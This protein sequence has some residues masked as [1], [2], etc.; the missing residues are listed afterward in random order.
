M[1]N[2]IKIKMTWIL[3]YLEFPLGKFLLFFKNF[4]IENK[5]KCIY[6]KY[7]KKN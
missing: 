3:I 2:I 4:F 6:M 1:K 5:N 7:I